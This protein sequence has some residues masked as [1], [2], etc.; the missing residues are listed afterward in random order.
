M[1]TR[2]RGVAC[3][4]NIGITAVVRTLRRDAATRIN[5]V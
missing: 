4:P 3:V 2:G 5:V 1:G